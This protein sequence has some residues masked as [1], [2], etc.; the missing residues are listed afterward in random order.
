MSSLF[1]KA[2][3]EHQIATIVD[4]R[5]EDEFLR[6]F[7]PGTRNIPLNSLLANPALVL[8]ADTP[9]ILSCRT[10]RRAMEV[11]HSLREQGYSKLYL[12][13]GGIEGW[14]RAGR[15][16][17]SKGFRFSLM[18]QV[19]IVAGSLILIG[20]LYQPLWFLAPMA[21][22]GLLVAGLTNTCLMA[23]ILGK[24]PWNRL[25]QPASVPSCCSK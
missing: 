25:P 8:S 10:G 3:E 9:I 12:L 7:I 5:T 11:F 4:V 16:V 21:G 14:K 15:P 6:E 23:V 24:M 22:F 1:P 2:I 13:E 20:S 18:Q 19:Q 17:I